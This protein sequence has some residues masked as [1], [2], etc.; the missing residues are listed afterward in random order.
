MSSGRLDISCSTCGTRRVANTGL[1]VDNVKS[2]IPRR[3]M[4]ENYP[5]LLD[6]HYLHID[7]Y[8]GNQ[9]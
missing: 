1:E 3:N 5:H 8:R 9:F 2:T 7:I 4:D 6:P